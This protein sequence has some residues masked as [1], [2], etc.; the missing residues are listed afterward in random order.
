VGGGP[1]VLRRPKGE[2]RIRNVG[3]GSGL[4]QSN[5]MKGSSES[6][7]VWV[8]VMNRNERFF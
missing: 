1:T 4:G 8:R 3:A 5:E 7:R 2:E 6:F